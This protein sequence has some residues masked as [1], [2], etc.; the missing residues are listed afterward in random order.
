MERE[1]WPLLYHELQA[2]ARDFRQKYVHFQPW[3]VAAVLLWAALHD[4][5]VSWACHERHWSTTR[6][7]PATLPSQPTV[8]RRSRKAVFALF[9]NHLSARFQGRGWPALVVLLDGKPL[10]VGGCSKDPDARF[11]R[12]PGH[13]GRGYKLHAAWGHRPLPEAWEVAPLNEHEIRVA[14]RLLRQLPG[15]YAV[16]DG[17]YDATGL[18]DVAGACNYQLL[19]KQHDANAGRGHHYQS[20]YRL[21]C[22]A[23]LQTPFGRELLALRPGIERRF[24]NATAFAGGVGGVGPPAWVRRRGRVERWVWA[25][26]VINAARIRRKERLAA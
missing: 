11:G 6:L 14:E 1:L 5:P 15:G 2:A 8:S 23:L 16:A 24:G 7:R 3:A 18:F 17:N 9:L 22:I 4:R 20:P 12:G 21:R 25:K 26:L 10:L 13:L 19:A